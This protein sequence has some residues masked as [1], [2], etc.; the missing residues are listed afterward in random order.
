MPEGMKDFLAY[1]PTLIILA[2]IL[3][4]YLPTW[5]EVRLRELEVSEKQAVSI[6]Q[7]ANSNN[8][9]A[10]A[11]G[12][13]ANTLKSVAIEQR[14]ATETIEILQ[15]MNTESAEIISQSVSELTGRVEE[16]EKIDVEKRT[17]SGAS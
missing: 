16:L 12:G 9:M 14:R 13:I 7:L 15:R 1:G 11:L 3:W 2:M 17:G 4:K 10:A 8:Q 5:K 6:G